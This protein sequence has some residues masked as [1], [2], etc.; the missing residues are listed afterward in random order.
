MST[1]TKVKRLSKIKRRIKSIYWPTIKK[2]T[3]FKSVKLKAGGARTTQ[4]IF[5]LR[6]KPTLKSPR[7]A[8]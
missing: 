1:M 2:K 8:A 3:S 7:K 6:L 5:G 4:W